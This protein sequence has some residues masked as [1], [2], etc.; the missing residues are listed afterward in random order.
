MLYDLL[1]RIDATPEEITEVVP[2]NKP[3]THWRYEEETGRQRTR[4]ID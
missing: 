2:G 1:E 3:K 4:K